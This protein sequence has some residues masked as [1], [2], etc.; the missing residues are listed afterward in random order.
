MRLFQGLKTNWGF[1]MKKTILFTAL[2]I[3]LS[4]FYPCMGVNRDFAKYPCIQNI[5]KAD[6]IIVMSDVHGALKEMINT[7][8]YTKVLDPID[9]SVLIN[10]AENIDLDSIRA[11]K[12]YRRIFKF[13]TQDSIILFCGDYIN[14]GSFSREVIDLIIFMEIEAKKNNSRVISL[15]GNHEIILLNSKMSQAIAKSNKK[16]AAYIPTLR[17]F[18]K[19]HFFNQSGDSVLEDIIKT[20]NPYSEWLL[21]RP[22]AARVEDIFFIHAGLDPDYSEYNRPGQ[23]IEQLDNQF[24]NAVQANKWNKKILF[25]KKSPLWIRDVKIE[26]NKQK[27]KKTPWFNAKSSVTKILTGLE[28]KYIVYGHDPG[29]LNKKGLIGTLDHRIF[30]IDVGMTPSK[31]YSSGGALLIKK[32]SAN[33]REFWAIESAPPTEASQNTLNSMFNERLLN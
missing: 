18:K 30:N 10:G 11:P 25:S 2:I 29:A 24:K 7:L 6:T 22:L 33:K 19:S 23:L 15:L 5:N 32:D 3:S 20:K 27:S 1:V 8:I 17:S 13:T 14:R 9:P 31:G 12:D 4:T 16:A 21:T 26:N 28:C